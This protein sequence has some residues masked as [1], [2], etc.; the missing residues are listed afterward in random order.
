MGCGRWCRVSWWQES[1][2]LLQ[3]LHL[4]TTPHQKN[5]KF[6][7]AVSVSVSVVCAGELRLYFSGEKAYLEDSPE[8]LRGERREVHLV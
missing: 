7:E 8:A 6:K 5:L 4:S 1:Y 3:S 2:K